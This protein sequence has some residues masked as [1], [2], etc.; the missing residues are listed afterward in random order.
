MENA[1]WIVA[2]SWVLRGVTAII[3]L[4]TLYF[5]FTGAPESV[6]IFTTIG[7]EPQGRIASGIAELIAGILILIPGTVVYGAALSLAVISGA[8]VSHLTVLG[9]ALPAVNDK[10]EL[11][12]LAVVVFLCSLLTLV[13]HRHEIPVLGSLLART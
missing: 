7:A 10:G 1:K 12:A 6:Y 5:K 9:I 4:Q 13:V 2:A 8:I 11:F 3:L